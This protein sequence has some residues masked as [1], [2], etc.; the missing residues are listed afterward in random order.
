M[1]IG[2]IPEHSLA[3]YQLAIDVSTDYVEPDFCLSKDGVF[4]AMHDLLLD[5]TTNVATMPQYA[6]RR[7]T[8]TVDGAP[9]TGFFVSDFTLEG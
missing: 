9:L 7:T 6:D 3:A 5:D 8:K 1:E 4:M 2:Y